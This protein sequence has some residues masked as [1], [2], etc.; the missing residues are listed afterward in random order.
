MTASRPTYLVLTTLVGVAFAS[1]GGEAASLGTDVEAERILS[2]SDVIVSEVHEVES[3]LPLSGSLDPHR[4]V[5]VRAQLSGTVL[6]ARPRAGERVSKGDLLVR[7]DART[8]EEQHSAAQSTVAAAQAALATA[9]HDESGA[10]IL[11]EAGAISEHDLRQARSVAEAARAQ[12]EA[13]RSQVGQAREAV[14]RTVVRSPMDGIVDRR[15]VS[16]GEAANPGQPLY[17]VVNVDTLELAAKVSAHHLSSVEVGAPVVFYVDAYP[18]RRFEGEVARVEPVADPA[19]RQLTAYVR[20]PNEDHELAGGLYATGLI[21][22]DR[23]EDA[24][25]VPAGA[26]RGS[27]ES[28]YVL[29]V[30]GGVVRR[31]PVVVGPTDAWS[32]RVVIR[33]GLSVGTTVVVGPEAGLKDGA[34][35]RIRAPEERAGPGGEGVR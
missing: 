31:N 13:A 24:V 30:E 21:V 22:G 28:G 15:L 27:P 7:Y 5:Q 3:G 20:L 19:T 18:G 33:K 29:A 16:D 23:T 2:P 34:R 17:S 26:L 25:T 12:L 1:C 11:A 14:S 10:E 8:F 9:E 6:E 4:S 35:V 32:D